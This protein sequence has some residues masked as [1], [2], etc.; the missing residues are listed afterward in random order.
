M[1]KIINLPF[2]VISYILIYFY[3]WCISPLL[4]KN[5]ASYPSCSSYAL[6]SIREHGIISGVALATKRLAVCSKSGKEDYPPLNI[7]GDKK[8]IF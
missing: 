7:K 2:L 4:N 8:W 3:K 1:K 5:C 6:L